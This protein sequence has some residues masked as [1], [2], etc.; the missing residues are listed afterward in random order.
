MDH[1]LVSLIVCHFALKW[2]QQQK[3]AKHRDASASAVRASSVRFHIRFVP[4]NPG[5]CEHIANV[6][7]FMFQGVIISLI[8]NFKLV[9]TSHAAHKHTRT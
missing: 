2:Q 6:K 3:E 5:Q 1:V 4:S 9:K 8:Y 7:H